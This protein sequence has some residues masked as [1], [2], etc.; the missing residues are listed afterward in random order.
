LTL[1]SNSRVY[2]RHKLAAGL[3][4]N[5]AKQITGWLYS[6]HLKMRRLNA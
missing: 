4:V 3:T 6:M 2:M 1:P 5:S